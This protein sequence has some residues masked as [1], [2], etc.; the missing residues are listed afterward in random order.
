MVAILSCPTDHNQYFEVCQGAYKQMLYVANEPTE[1]IQL[2]CT[3]CRQIMTI[4]KKAIKR[5]GN[6]W[7]Y[8]I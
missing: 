5:D 1:F 8:I 7:V 2:F 6:H 4:E 3:T